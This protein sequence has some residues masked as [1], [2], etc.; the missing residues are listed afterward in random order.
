MIADTDIAGRV[1]EKTGLN[2]SH[3]T[4]PDASDPMNASAV[5]F[6]RIDVT[7]KTPQE[8]FQAIREAG[9]KLA[10]L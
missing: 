10:K 2:V 9:E 8:I 5:I 3:I 4:G 7:D 1:Y 6:V